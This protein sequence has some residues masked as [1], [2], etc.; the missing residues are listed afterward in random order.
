MLH[1]FAYDAR[2]RNG[3]VVGRVALITLLK[4]RGD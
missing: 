1:G 2:Q 3:S 4:E